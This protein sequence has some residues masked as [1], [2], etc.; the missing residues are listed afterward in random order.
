MNVNVNVDVEKARTCLLRSDNFVSL[1]IQQYS[2]FITPLLNFYRFD[3]SS[4]V[5]DVL[6]STPPDPPDSEA[7]PDVPNSNLSMSDDTD[8]NSSED[9]SRDFPSFSISPISVHLY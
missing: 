9:K 2:A 6:D 5:F 1:I 7:D 8:D 3:S 4:F